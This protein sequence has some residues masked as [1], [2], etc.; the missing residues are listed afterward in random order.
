MPHW[1]R[2]TPSQRTGLEMI[3]RFLLLTCPLDPLAWLG[4][5]KKVTLQIAVGE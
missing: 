2:V 1:N 3:G 4:K 5:L